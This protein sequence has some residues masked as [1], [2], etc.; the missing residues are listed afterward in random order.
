MINSFDRPLFMYFLTNITCIQYTC[1][2]RSNIITQYLSAKVHITTGVVFSED[3]SQFDFA[4]VSSTNQEMCVL[5][6]AWSLGRWDAFTLGLLLRF[7]Q[8]ANWSKPT[9]HTRPYRLELHP[10]KAH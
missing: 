5:S 1:I 3:K 7:I 4:R 10:S 6:V 8:A 2:H 9:L